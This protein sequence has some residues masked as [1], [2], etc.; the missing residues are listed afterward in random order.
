MPDLRDGEEIEVPGSSGNRYTVK[1]VGGVYACSCMAWR[2]QSVPVDRRT[3][4]HIRRLRGDAA[5]DIRIGAVAAPKA[6]AKPKPAP[7]PPAVAAMRLPAPQDTEAV[8]TEYLLAGGEV[9]GF[10]ARTGDGQ[11][12]AVTAGF[13]DRDLVCPPPV[14]GIVT[15]RFQEV[16][17][18]GAPY[19]P[20][21]AGTRP[22][23]APTL[24]PAPKPGK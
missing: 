21:Y 3:C 9:N 12:V 6:A 16:T 24:P 14:G 18:T 19:S 11:M 8:V 5:E 1:N 4:K 13:A 10:R 23:D 2:T 20:G 17:A 22:D 15:L 7:A